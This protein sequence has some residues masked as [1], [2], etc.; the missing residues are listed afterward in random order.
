LELTK[1]KDKIKLTVPYDG[2]LMDFDL[3][4]M[5]AAVC[6]EELQS[7]MFSIWDKLEATK[8][9]LSQAGQSFFYITVCNG[10]AIVVFSYVKT[11]SAHK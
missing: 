8:I 3:P 7:M 2:R 5:A 11:W 1:L 9:K 6:R 10:H 4:E